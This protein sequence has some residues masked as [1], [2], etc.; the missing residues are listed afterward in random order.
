MAAPCIGK[1]TREAST[2][3]SLGPLLA[4]GHTGGQSVDEQRRVEFLVRLIQLKTRLQTVLILMFPSA[5][6]SSDKSVKVWDV[7]TRTCVHTFFD[8]QDQVRRSSNSHSFVFGG[9][10]CLSAAADADG[11]PRSR[12]A[13]GLLSLRGWSDS[14]LPAYTVCAVGLESC[15]V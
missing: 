11:R 6:S 15:E 7:G 5:H 10:R 12:P 8:H 3:S 1:A 14:Q 2:Q 9:W 13:A 4:R